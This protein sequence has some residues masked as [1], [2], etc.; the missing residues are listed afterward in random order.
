M[1]GLNERGREDL[2]LVPM[3]SMKPRRRI[4]RTR[5]YRQYYDKDFLDLILRIRSRGDFEAIIHMGAC[6]STTLQDARYFK[7]N[8][9]EYT[10]SLAQWALK[11]NVRFIYSYTTYGQF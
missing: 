7:E 2:I 5:K 10:R 8:N 3:N 6:S 1:A 4:S 9:L 11:P